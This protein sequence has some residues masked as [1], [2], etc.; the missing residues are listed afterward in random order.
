MEKAKTAVSVSGISDLQGVHLNKNKQKTNKT[1]KA[2]S[3]KPK[4]YTVTTLQR[5]CSGFVSMLN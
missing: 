3:S 1:K 5:E 2:F 4:A